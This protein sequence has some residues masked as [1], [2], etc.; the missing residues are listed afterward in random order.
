MKKYMFRWVWMIALLFLSSTTNAQQKMPPP[1]ERAQKLT[2]WMTK[3]L[4]LGDKQVESVQAINLKYANK[5]QELMGGSMSKPQI[6][7]ALR[8]DGDARD[9]EL[10]Q[11]FTAQQFQDWLVKKEDA[12]KYIKEKMKAKNAAD[13]V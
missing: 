10:K 8:A 2:E 9:R 7:R 1:E 4:Q 12:K 6:K 3:T 11:V 13:D 5:T